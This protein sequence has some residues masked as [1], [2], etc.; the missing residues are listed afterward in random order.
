MM[1][2]PRVLQAF[3]RDDIFHWLRQLGRGSGPNNE[4]RRAIVLTFTISQSCIV[5]A[6]LNAIAPII[7]MAFMITYGLINFA[8]FCEAIARNPSYRPRFRF[9]HWSTSLLG[10]LACLAVMFLIDWFWAGISIG[11]LGGVYWIISRKE[12]ASR[13]GDVQRGLLFERARHNLIQLEDEPPHPKNWRP[14]ILAL[15]GVGWSRPHLAAF[16]H[17]FTA[18]RGILS[19]GQV[20]HGEVEDRLQ[21]RVNQERLLREFIQEYELQAFPAVVVAPD[22]FAGI[23]FLVQCHGLGAMRPNTVLLGWPEHPERAQEFGS[24]LRTVAGLECSIVALR[25]PEEPDDPWHAPR[26]TIDVWWRGQGNGALMLLLAH[27]LTQ[28]DEWRGRP[29]RLLR[30]VPNAEARETIFI[31]GIILSAVW[32]SLHGQCLR[33]RRPSACRAG[34]VGSAAK[35]VGTHRS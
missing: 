6:D 24:M 8:T 26:G 3:A 19:L 20:I 15:S 35:S 18:G 17:W 33:S 5:V 14:V 27:L 25:F 11:A 21:R 32:L 23:E 9:S 22:L 7:T 13:W 29:I 4:P 30:V 34:R 1:G 12:V 10:A 28:N 31:M 2:A 16:G